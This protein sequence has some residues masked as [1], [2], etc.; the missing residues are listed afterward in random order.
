MISQLAPQFT[1]NPMYY[2]SLSSKELFHS[3]FLEF[4]FNT[5]AAAFFRII[6]RILGT[7]FSNSPNIYSLFREKE[8]FD[9]CIAHNVKTTKQNRDAWYYDLIIENKVKSIPYKS[10]LDGYQ[11]KA[12][13]HNAKYVG[14]Q[15]KLLL[16]SLVKNFP[17]LADVRK[18][19]NWTVVHYDTLCQEIQN[20]YSSHRT[21]GALVKDYCKFLQSLDQLQGVI[22]NDDNGLF[23][24]AKAY[25]PYRFHDLYAKL[26]SALFL[27][28]FKKQIEH[29]VPPCG[30]QVQF[31]DSIKNVQDAGFATGIYLH[32]GMN[33]GLGVADIWIPIQTPHKIALY[34]IV[35]QGNQY[36][37]GY[38]EPNTNGSA[39]PTVDVLWNTVV[40][41]LPFYTGFVAG[42]GN[43]QALS[44]SNM[45]G[46]YCQ[47]NN[48]YL[49][50]YLKIENVRR[51]DLLDI[52]INDTVQL[53][54]SHNLINLI[55]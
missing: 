13:N 31:V 50:T 36:R 46:N 30:L 27:M 33:Q 34:E 49:Y 42:Q 54:R 52:A 19:Q 5:D 29:R 44:K 53:L 47:Y 28:D 26:R 14:A 12:D 2:F 10:Q 6:D 23:N 7:T 43:F 9:I 22:I 1:G 3:N 32:Y 55:P 4:L 20:E 45:R 38:C 51:N 21:I 17:N 16:I 11:K 18:Q 40:P 35:I 39:Q 48:D 25:A 15:A 8:N 24:N 41:Q 37:H